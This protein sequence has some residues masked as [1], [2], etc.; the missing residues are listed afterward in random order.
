M[1][2]ITA[3]QQPSTKPKTSNATTPSHMRQPT[4]G[5][6]V[7]AGQ[8]YTPDQVL[9]LQRTVGNQVVQRLLDAQRPSRAAGVG[10]IQPKLA[11]GP[12]NDRYEQ[13]A[14]RV[15][16]QVVSMSPSKSN[17]PIQRHD[18]DDEVQMKPL[19]KSITP[20]VRRHPQHANEEQVVQGKLLVQRHP[21]HAEEEEVLQGKRIAQ[22]SN[23]V[24]RHPS[25]AEE[26]EVL[27]GKRSVQRRVSGANIGAEGGAL[28]QQ[29]ERSIRSAQGGQP[30]EK[31][32]RGSMEQA[33]GADF[34][35]VRV[36]TNTKADTLNRSLQARAFTTGQNIFFKQG[37]YNPNSQGGKQLL[38]HELTHV[39]QQNSNVVQTK[40]AQTLANPPQTDSTQTDNT[41]RQPVTKDGRGVIRRNFFKRL[42]GIGKKKREAKMSTKYGVPIGSSAE[43]AGDKAHFSHGMLDKIDKVLGQLPEAHVSGNDKLKTIGSIT[44]TDREEARVSGESPGAASTYAPGTGKI[45]MNKPMSWMPWWL[46]TMLSPKRKW[47]RKMMDQGAMEGYK[48]ISPETD[49]QLG[50]T[51]RSVFAGVSD[52]MVKKGGLATGTLRHE[53]GHA[54]DDK[55]KFTRTRAFLPLFGGWRSY[56]NDDRIGK[57][58][59][60]ALKDAG[61]DNRIINLEYKSFKAI[62]DFIA[63]L[64]A[65]RSITPNWDA[66]EKAR[67]YAGIYARGHEDIEETEKTQLEQAAIPGL[68]KFKEFVTWANVQPWT[69]SDGA[70]DHLELGDGRI[71]QKDHYG[72]WVSYLSDKRKHAVSNYQFS[73]PGEWFAEAYT[74]Y[75][76]PDPNFEGRENLEPGVRAWFEK[77]LGHHEKA[78]R[79][80]ASLVSNDNKLRELRPFDMKHGLADPTHEREE[81][82]V[83]PQ[84][85]GDLMEALMEM[86]EFQEFDMDIEK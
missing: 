43:G 29:T 84:E 77:N 30:L 36:H 35:G 59:R 48:G 60:K 6:T 10:I 13:E 70:K 28:D 47:Q 51:D 69:I 26:E 40:R 56:S 63:D 18:S 39:V 58:A 19:A 34:G 20:M 79:E 50:I 16:K 75:Y 4:P 54:V 44:P 82:E 27:Q 37:Q 55:I 53:M 76:D 7:S 1:T 17:G 8:Q 24:Q 86:N 32:T 2:R 9:W 85:D 42:F 68:E 23:T 83:L 38:A 73:S 21:S 12:V 52:A 41:Q 65:Q 33:F 49:T 22:N 15:A 66:A 80:Q 62:K 71:Y 78:H 45:S 64:K 57:I 3:A 67:G 81:E 74:A 11:V 61:V 14:D 72:G 25:H 31:Q 46:Y 5:G